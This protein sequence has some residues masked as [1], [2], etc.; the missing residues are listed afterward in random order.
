MKRLVVA[1][2]LAALSGCFRTESGT[3][4]AL[5]AGT[6]VPNLG[7]AQDPVQDAVSH[8]LMELDRKIATLE[9]QLQSP[10]RKATGAMASGPRLRIESGGQEALLDRL[11]R[12]EKE[13]AV[14][15]ATIQTKEAQIHNLEI[16]RADLKATSTDL[17]QRNDYLSH[18]ESSLKTAQQALAERHEKLAQLEAQLN[19]SELARLRA[20][21]EHYL[22]A[23]DILRMTPEQPAALPEI[24][25][26]IREQARALQNSTS[27]GK[28]SP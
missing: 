5:P 14:A 2:G 4:P 18:T 1:V 7:T 28:G 25:G 9:Q 11:R 19:A 10:Q 12:L 6:P 26:R 8:R 27:T 15:N 3:T 23:A 13:L 20:E 16:T 24:Q 22:L 21:R 17:T